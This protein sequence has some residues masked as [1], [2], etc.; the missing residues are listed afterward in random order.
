MPYILQE[1]RGLLNRAIVLLGNIVRNRL[2]IEDRPGALNFIITK[3]I[4]Q[5]MP[6]RYKD[7]NEMIGVL[8]CVKMELYRTIIASYEDTKIKENGDII[9][10]KYK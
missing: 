3:L 5:F 8:E 6:M 10:E 2:P 1:Q 7:F 4:L 9:Y